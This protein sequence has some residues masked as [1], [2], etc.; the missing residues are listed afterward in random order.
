MVTR[1]EVV[2]AYRFF[3]GR[4]PESERVIERWLPV[5]DWLSL[6]DVFLES[7]EFHAKFAAR[8]ETLISPDDV[9]AEPNHVEIDISDGQ[10][11]TLIEH[12]QGAW[13]ALGA[14]KPHWS[15]LTDPRFLPDKI[16]A[17]LGGFYES[18]AQSWELVERAA[19]R[20][21]DARQSDQ[22]GTRRPWSRVKRSEHL[23]PRRA[24]A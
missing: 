18:G 14:E 21:R 5:E 22:A 2:H 15:V 24:P 11:R 10:Y 4:D 19:A 13:E 1:E 12:V 9:L 6:R 16:E 3:F 20:A 17:N 8:L 23:R 7:S